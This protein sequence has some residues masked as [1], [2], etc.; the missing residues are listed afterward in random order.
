MSGACDW[1]LL[2]LMSC[3]G[4]STSACSGDHILICLEVA[5]VFW[6]FCKPTL[7]MWFTH[8][9][10][11][12]ANLDAGSSGPLDISSEDNAL[13]TDLPKGLGPRIYVGGIPSALSQTMIR[14]HFSQYGKVCS[15]GPDSLAG[16]HQ[17]V[18]AFERWQVVLLVNFELLYWCC[19]WWMYTFPSTL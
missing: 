13:I 9:K 16:Q 11:D 1:Q 3:S 4:R 7:H 17:A 12:L 14:N 6:K 5:I 19:R 2:K 18:I 15:A 8:I 10:L